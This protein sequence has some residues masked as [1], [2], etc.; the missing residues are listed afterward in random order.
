MIIRTLKGLL[1]A[2]VVGSV[3]VAAP[4]TATVHAAADAMLSASPNSN[5]RDG[6]Q[7]TVTGTDYPPNAS[8]DLVQC[9]QGIGCDLSN[10][11]L[12]QTDANGGYT[13]MFTVRRIIDIHD[14]QV[15]CVAKQDCVL[16]S[17]DYVN[18]LA[19]AQTAITFDPNAP[20]KPPLHFRV[21][22]DTNAH[23][24]PDKGVVRVTGNVYCNQPADISID[25]LLSQQYNRQIFQSENY[26]D[27]ACAHGGHFSVVLRPQNGLFAAG[28]ARL[29]INA[30][31]GTA[32]SNYNLS[33]HVTLT[34]TP[35]AS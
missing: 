2:A 15:D 28:T 9:E 6:Q 8:V 23:V 7:L 30:F 21:A 3:L 14:Q 11:V 25:L 34:L 4:A 29:D 17:V 5:L 18:Y 31:G 27:V 26:T 24:Q 32:T 16:V 20:F 35:S 10:N 1:A 22:P 33:K 19:A 13:A 12:S